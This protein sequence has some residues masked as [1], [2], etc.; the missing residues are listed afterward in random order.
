M[1]SSLGR[2]TCHGA[3]FRPDIIEAQPRGLG[4]R[5]PVVPGNAVTAKKVV[6]M[7]GDRLVKPRA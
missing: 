2:P 6:D 7:P 4:P 3:H 1:A 5:P